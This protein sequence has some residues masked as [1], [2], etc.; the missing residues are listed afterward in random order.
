MVAASNAND[1]QSPIFFAEED[2]VA[3]DVSR[4]NEYRRQDRF[5]R[6]RCQGVS[7]LSGTLHESSQPIVLRQKACLWR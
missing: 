2:D 4:T 5:D 1:F 7:Q 6:H 3:S